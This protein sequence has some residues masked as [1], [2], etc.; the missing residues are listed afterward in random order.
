MIAELSDPDRGVHESAEDSLLTNEIGVVDG[1]RRHRDRCE[2][3]VEIDG[4]PDLLELAESAE[5]PCDGDRIGRLALAE[6]VHD[7]VV[8]GLV[9][10]A[11]EIGATEHF[12]DVRDGILAHH[13]CAEYGLLRLQILGRRAVKILRHS[14]SAVQSRRW[15]RE[16]CESIATHA[17]RQLFHLW[18]SM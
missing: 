13:H 16:T 5:F 11:I 14:S 7:G 6:Q 3:I 12:D 1:V 18:A 8:D 15:P 17:S 10:G 4:T 9:V 2:Q